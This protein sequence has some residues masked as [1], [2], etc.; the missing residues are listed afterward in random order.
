MVY[1]NL[2]DTRNEI[3][4]YG[5]TGRANSTIEQT[6]ANSI[7]PYEPMRPNSLNDYFSRPEWYSEPR[8]IQLGIEVRW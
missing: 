2:F 1:H 6:R 4:V 3:S 8:S 5:D 7:S